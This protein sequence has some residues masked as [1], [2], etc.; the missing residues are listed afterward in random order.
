MKERV[1]EKNQEQFAGFTLVRMIYKIIIISILVH[2]GYCFV[3]SI[4][5]LSPIIGD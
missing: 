2:C 4:L 5:I 1:L 3:G